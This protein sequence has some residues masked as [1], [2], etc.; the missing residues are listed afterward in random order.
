[1]GR[2]QRWFA[3]CDPG[4]GKTWT[5]VSDNIPCLPPLGTVTSIEAS[6]YEA[7]KAYMTIY[8]HQVNNHDLFVYKTSD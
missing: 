2:E 3:S 6:R 7:G 1:M 5:R 8:F 4:W